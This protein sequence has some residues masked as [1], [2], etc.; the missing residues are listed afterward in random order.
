MPDISPQFLV[1]GGDGT[2][3]QTLKARLQ[4]EGL[5]YSATTRRTAPTS[6]N[7]YF[8]LAMSPEN[9]P[10]L[11]QASVVFIC[12]AITKL[13]RCED[14][15]QATQL[16]NITHMQS[17]IERIQ[18]YGGLVVFLSSNQVFD[19]SKPYR[20]A[21]EHPCPINEYGKQK[22]A[23]EQ[24][25]LQRPQPSA[26]LR[27]TKVINGPLP[28]TH[29]WQEKFETHSAVEAFDDLAFSPLPLV[30]VLDG[31]IAIG[32]QRRTGIFQLSGKKQLSYYEIA[33]K[34]AIKMGKS[35]KLVKSVSAQ[36]A[37][38]RSQFL[39]RFGT[40]DC[41]TLANITIP[42]TDCL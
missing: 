18:Y 24:W 15:P 3:G 12:A 11:P 5:G 2:I 19:G 20:Q 39:P 23:I 29:I 27:L 22:V 1:I 36:A 26:I 34:L 25:L 6:S 14:D 32:T 30:S 4:E 41:T 40:L 35:T 17:L 42:D 21:W 33:C 7:I 10:V 9:W 37:G 8:D 31:L 13:D 28:I 16:I 38:I